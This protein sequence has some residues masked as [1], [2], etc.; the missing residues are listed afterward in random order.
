MKK[1]ILLWGVIG[2]VLAALL[3]GCQ[4]SS[5][6][7]ILGGGMPEQ[8]DGSFDVFG[9]I[10]DWGEPLC[11]AYV[12]VQVYAPFG[13]TEWWG[14]KNAWTNEDGEYECFGCSPTDKDT[15]VMAIYPPLPYD[16]VRYSPV[17]IPV[18]G[19]I[20]EVNI[21]FAFQQEPAR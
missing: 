11:P 21:D 16:D 3:V 17:W 4:D 6:P 20:Y 14:V 5:D 13:D 15:R 19:G 12:E 1:E 2:A 7:G 9:K 10:T 18:D 8:T